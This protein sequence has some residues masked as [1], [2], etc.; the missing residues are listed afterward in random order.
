MQHGRTADGATGTASLT[1]ARVAP[2]QPLVLTPFK[3]TGI[4]ALGENVGWTVALPADSAAGA[5]EYTYTIKKNNYEVIKRGTLDLSRPATIEVSLDEPAM[6][7]VEVKSSRG[8]TLFLQFPCGCAR[9]DHET[10]AFGQ[11]TKPLA[12]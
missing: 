7:Y 4:Y 8:Y 6:L 1:L 9:G 12:R 10:S 2:A 3:P 5:T 11:R